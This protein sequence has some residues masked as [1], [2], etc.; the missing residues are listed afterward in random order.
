MKKKLIYFTLSIV[1]LLLLFA[2]YFFTIKYYDRKIQDGTDILS[3]EKHEGIP[4]F[5]I[6]TYFVDGERFYFKLPIS[7]NDTIMAFGDTGGGISFLAP[8][9]K[10]KGDIRLD[11]KMG[12]VKGIMPIEYILYKDLV[13]NVNFP[14]PSPNS[15]FILRNPFK[16]VINPFL[17]IPPMDDELKFMFKVQPEMEA[18][19]GQTFFME[20]SWTIDYPNE[21]IMVNTPLSDSL[22]NQPN[23]QKLGFKKNAKQE[24]ING[25]P[26]MTVEVD[27]E[28]IDVLFDTGATMVLTE[29]G[30][31]QFG[32][33][34]KTL[35]GSF[36]AA[37]IFNKWR[38]EHPEWKYYPKADYGG[39]VIEVPIVKIGE[40]EVGP[41]L[42][43]VKRDEAWSEGM[44]NTMDKVV[45]G[46]IGGTLLKFF[47]VT[48]DYNS[49]LIR[50]ER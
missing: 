8:N 19:L 31:K 36:I 46:A 14:I 48:I 20:H 45:K 16:R 17:M 22:I 44:I 38:K 29:A 3:S 28:T 32:T 41:V 49:D 30:Q 37:S 43:V 24:K 1:I 23:V 40:F 25:H 5:I 10:N 12:I 34:K 35:A 21:Q 4:N 7:N 50:F 11:L 39:D 2:V 42:F 6:P 18:F 15:T 27:G 13:K 9:A 33:D 47:K 26:S